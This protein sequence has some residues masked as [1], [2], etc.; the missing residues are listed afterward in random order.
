MKWTPIIVALLW[1]L[2]TPML[3]WVTAS[4]QISDVAVAQGRP[5]RRKPAGRKGVCAGDRSIGELTAV[6]AATGTDLT[7]SDTPSF[8]F[9][10]PDSPQRSLKAIFRLQANRRNIIPPVQLSLTG[11]PGIIKVQLPK[12]IAKDQP[13][14]WSFDV[15][16][17]VENRFSLQGTVISKAINLELVKQLSQLTSP[18]DRA[19]L[20]QKEGL[21]LDA[22]ATLAEAQS[23]DSTAKQDWQ[24][25]LQTLNLP[26]LQQQP[27]VP[28][29]TIE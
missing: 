18:R 22:V 2:S 3:D 26:E 21:L 29:C 19:A 28:C 23:Q 9:F 12:A 17:G 27:I 13:F 20:Y 1:A 15:S 6:V 10:I 4:S 5:K 8:L 24:Q 7:I 11:T 14:Q 16:C 25:L